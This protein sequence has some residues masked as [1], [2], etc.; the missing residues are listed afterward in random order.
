[1][2]NVKHI[3]IDTLGR[4]HVVLQRGTI[5]MHLVA[6]GHAVAIA[7]V[8]LGLRIERSEEIGATAQRLASTWTQAGHLQGKVRKRRARPRVSPVVLTF[9]VSLGHLSGLRGT[10]LFQSP[11]MQFLDRK[12]AELQDLAFEASSRGW[13]TY[14]SSGDVVE[15]TLPEPRAAS[16]EGPS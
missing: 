7:P 15:I 1:M 9:A 6:S 2:A 11:W 13:M 3:L 14:R 12:P 5:H 16:G 8:T 4:Q 10:L